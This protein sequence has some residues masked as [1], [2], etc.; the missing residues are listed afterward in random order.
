MKTIA[1]IITVFFS[2]SGYS[3]T[4]KAFAA[5]DTDE[6]PNEVRMAFKDMEPEHSADSWRV[7]RTT[8]EVKFEKDDHWVFHRF[9]DEGLYLET[10]TLKSWGEDASEEIKEG[11]KKT[12]YK[13]YDVIAFYEA[14][15]ADK[16]IYY[17][18]MLEDEETNDLQTLYFENDGSL[19]DK[20]KSGF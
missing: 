14:K 1:F 6:V 2:I 20:S 13:Y 7:E 10:R 12:T 5:I 16:D 8:Y 18:L 11:K 17:V 15:T 3:Q 19:R 9:N 4:A